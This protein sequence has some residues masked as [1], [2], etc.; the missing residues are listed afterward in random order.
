MKKTLLSW[1]SGKDSAWALHVL[2]QDAQIHV[3]GLFCT[4]NEQLD[5][6]AMHAVRVA[7]LRAQAES[8]ALP[9]HLISIPHPCSNAD[10]ARIMGEFVSRERK[11]GIEYFAFGD[12]FLGDIRAYRESSLSGTG[13]KPLFPLWGMNTRALSA[14]MLESGLRA[15][16]TCVDPSQ[17]APEFC[18]REYDRSFLADLPSQVDPCGENGEFHSFAFDGPMFRRKINIEVG[19]TTL[20]DK[21]VFTDLLPA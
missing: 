15:R 10:Y 9:V 5:R 4:V 14:T 19:E 12:L 11:R 7:L 1:S 13:V 18:G 21:F 6:V 8:V 17:L 2:R 16:V 3:D 20:R